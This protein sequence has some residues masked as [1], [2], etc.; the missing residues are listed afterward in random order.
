MESFFANKIA[1]KRA[2]RAE[3]RLAMEAAAAA[4][5]A[6]AALDLSEEE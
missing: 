3:K 6:A 5:A 1:T 2:A 4:A